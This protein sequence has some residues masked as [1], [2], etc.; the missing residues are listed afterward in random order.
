MSS[1]FLFVKM[2]LIILIIKPLGEILKA[3]FLEFDTRF[4]THIKN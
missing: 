1:L 4:D 2:L 3:L